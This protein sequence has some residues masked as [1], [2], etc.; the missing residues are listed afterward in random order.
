MSGGILGQIA[1]KEDFLHRGEIYMY[2]YP[3]KN[4][5]NILQ[6]PLSGYQKNNSIN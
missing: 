1:D 2:I 4:A 5:A 3:S 6:P